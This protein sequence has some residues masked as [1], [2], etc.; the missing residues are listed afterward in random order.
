MIALIPA[1]GGS[2]RVPRKN[3][4]MAGGKPLIAWTIEAAR[5]ARSVDRVVV[6]TEDRE[7]AEVARQ[8]G[9]E[10]P[11]LRPE[12]LSTD[13]ATSADVVD[14]ALR[15]L[16]LHETPDVCFVLLQP[17]SPLRTAADIDSAAALL[18]NTDVVISVTP[19]PHSME[20][21]RIIDE[22]GRLRPWVGP[23]PAA[24]AGDG[25]LYQLNGAIYMMRAG[26]FLR[27]GDLSPAMATAYVMPQ[28]RSLDVDTEFDLHLCDLILTA[29]ERRV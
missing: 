15:E 26:R 16:R 11:F 3:L 10:A 28:E 23:G 14:H 27:D 21:L 8:H 13:T 4:R 22:E 6:T 19:L 2:R 9:A 29:N 24:L 25:P 20:W 18:Q 12:H 7:I 1:R 17:T 5:S